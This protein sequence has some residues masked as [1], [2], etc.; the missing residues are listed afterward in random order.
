MRCEGC[1]NY[2]E[3]TTIRITCHCG[4]VEVIDSDCPACNR[5]EYMAALC[6]DCTKCLETFV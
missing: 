3:D 6:D 5:E 1:Q 2:K 4:S